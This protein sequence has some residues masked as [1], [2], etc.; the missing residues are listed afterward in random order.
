MRGYP[1][2]AA[3]Q[4]TALLHACAAARTCPKKRAKSHQQSLC[5]PLPLCHRA[6]VPATQGKEGSRG[7][8]QAGKGLAAAHPWHWDVGRQGGRGTAPAYLIQIVEE[9]LEERGEG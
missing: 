7:R 8:A 5:C 6:P 9:A 1:R 2:G 4:D 3:G